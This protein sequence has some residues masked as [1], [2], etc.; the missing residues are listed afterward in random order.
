MLPA[1]SA[2]IFFRGRWVNNT[3]IGL[4]YILKIEKITIA[5]L[6]LFQNNKSNYFTCTLNIS[7]FSVQLAD[8]SCTSIQR[9]DKLLDYRDVQFW[10]MKETY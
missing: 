1:K 4:E 5:L 9:N 6:I 2:A 3:C 10:G 7:S 8:N